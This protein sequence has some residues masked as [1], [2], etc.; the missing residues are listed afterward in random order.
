MGRF[1]IGRIRLH[2]ISLKNGE[3]FRLGQVEAQGFHSDFEL[4]VIDAI[5]LV[6]IKQ[7]KLKAGI[8]SMPRGKPV[9]TPVNVPMW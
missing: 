2:A 6:Q 8:N 1:R 7:A 9:A 5:I 3:N 4:M